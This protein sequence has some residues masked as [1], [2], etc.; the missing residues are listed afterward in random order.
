[1]DKYT[2]SCVNYTLS[3]LWSCLLSSAIDYAIILY[4][5]DNKNCFYIFILHI[6][7]ALH[8]LVSEWTATCG[9]RIWMCKN[10]I[11]SLLIKITLYPLST[12]NYVCLFR[13]YAL[14]LCFVRPPLA[15]E[16]KFVLEKPLMRVQSTGACATSTRCVQI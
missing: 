4:Y 9:M 10:D 7:A 5:P 11:Y 6:Y 15:L 16:T 14:S 3:K 12:I 13:T 1:M 8:V 2:S